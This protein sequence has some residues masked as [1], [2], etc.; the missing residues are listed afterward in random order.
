MLLAAIQ[1][2]NLQDLRGAEN[3]LD[4][5]CT[6]AKWPDLQV[7]AAWTQ[8][9]DWHLKLGMDVESARASLQKIADRFPGTEISL[10]A[11]Q[12]MAHLVETEKL[13]LAQHDRALVAVPEGVHNLGLRDS[14]SMIK[15]VEIEPGKLAEAHI[16]HLAAHPH[17][18]EV[19]E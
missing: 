18:S 11:E 12:R 17:D 5:G 3:I 10:R 2:E 7:A 8:V 16:K 13:L 4:I 15:P 1:A 19:R 14:T 6:K 9:A